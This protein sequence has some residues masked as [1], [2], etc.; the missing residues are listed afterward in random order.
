[1]KIL[2]IGP[3]ASGKGTVSKIL[4]EKLNI[5]AISSGALL[6]SVPE[7]NEH[8]NEINKSMEAGDPVDQNI[9]AELLKQRVA[10]K[11]CENG[12]I[13]DGWARTS[14]DLQ[15]FDPGFDYVIE[16]QITREESLRRITGRRICE[17]D[18]KVYNIN[19]LPQQAINCSG[20]LIQRE[21]DTAEVV[22]HRLDLYY[23]QTEE[24]LLNFENKG[25]LVKVDGMP[26][27]DEVAS[28]IISIVKP[29]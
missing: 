14:I 29:N 16:I 12:Y 24:V 11:D 28:N 10:E 22:N 7:S 26:L 4:S 2:L 18:G 25:L 1:M 6:R 15:K 27:P 8:Y 17:S 20:N 13:L 19:T 3:P 23:T 9:V 5:P 21:D